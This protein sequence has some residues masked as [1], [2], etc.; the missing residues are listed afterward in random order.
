MPYQ[1]LYS[2]P[3]VIQSD[4]ENRMIVMWSPFANVARAF[5]ID[6]EIKSR[7]LDIV[8]MPA[9]ALLVYNTRNGQFINGLTGLTSKGARPDDFKSEIST[10]KTTWKHWRTLHP[11]SKVLVSS[12][13]LSHNPPA[14]PV[15]PL[16]PLPRGNDPTPSEKR[17]VIV[18]TTQPIA[19]PTEAIT[20]K[21][22]NVM[23][24]KLPLL[25]FRDGASGEVKAFDRR[26]DE[27][28]MPRF[29]IN[30]DTRR[31]GAAFVDSDTNTGWN[32]EGIAVDGSKDRK[33]K[34]LKAVRIEEDVYWG[35]MKWWYPEMKL[36]E[37]K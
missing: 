20:T 11:E 35:V 37:N 4:H 15:L 28:L 24:G 10:T 31:K 17:V 26:I 27:D 16:Y 18:P 6:R 25:I 13:R 29:D 9:N 23:A 33:G 21:P 14:A 30:R 1:A 5:N 8:S 22:L 7:E 3:V 34:K 2:T 32:E 12:G 19:L 36:I